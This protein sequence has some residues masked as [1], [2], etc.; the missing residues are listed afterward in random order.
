[1]TWIFGEM[2]ESV[3]NQTWKRQQ[4]IDQLG[5]N[6]KRGFSRGEV[7]EDILGETL[8]DVV[9]FHLDTSDANNVVNE[10][11]ALGF[12]AYTRDAE[13]QKNCALNDLLCD[14]V[15]DEFLGNQWTAL[16]TAI[17]AGPGAAPKSICGDCWETPVDA[18]GM[19]CRD[20]AAVHLR[21]LV[22]VGA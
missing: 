13:H 4:F 15:A 14:V 19:R 17:A 10:I 16:Q 9:P 5:H 11:L 7:G 6:L 18:P 12:V 21:L 20:C 8:L 2:G 22:G 1:M 3:D